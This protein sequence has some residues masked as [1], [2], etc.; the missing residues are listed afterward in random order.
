MTIFNPF[1]VIT[2]ERQTTP[3]AIQHSIPCALITNSSPLLCSN[4]ACLGIRKCI[5]PGDKSHFSTS[6]CFPSETSE[7]PGQPVVRRKHQLTDCK[8]QT[9]TLHMYY[10][11]CTHNIILMAIPRLK[12]DAL[13]LMKW[14][15]Y[16]G[17]MSSLCPTN[18]VKALMAKKP[19]N[20]KHQ[21]CRTHQLWQS[22]NHV[23]EWPH[24]Q[25]VVHCCLT[26]LSAQT[27]YIMP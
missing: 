5:Q 10:W 3:I 19:E 15:S 14:A 2:K 4:T 6:K 7:D 23:T 26:A 11:V 13:K 21:L 1:R 8:P 16:G 18:N 9:H 24:S 25:L 20:C 22:H 17:Q 12:S 27:G